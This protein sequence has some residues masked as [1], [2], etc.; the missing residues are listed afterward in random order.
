MDFGVVQTVAPDIIY[1]F[2]LDLVYLTQ[3]HIR[4]IIERFLGPSQVNKNT[5]LWSDI[6]THTKDFAA[7][8]KLQ[9]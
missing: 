6:I 7:I 1:K 5:F 2:C 4:N 9:S 3:V 8:I